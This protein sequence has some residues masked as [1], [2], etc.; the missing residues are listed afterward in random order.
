MK[1]LCP[2]TCQYCRAKPTVTLP[3]RPKKVT[4]PDPVEGNFQDHNPC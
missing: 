3:T 4:E 1:L 2:R